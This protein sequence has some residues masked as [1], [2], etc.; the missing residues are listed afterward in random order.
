MNL[1]VVTYIYQENVQTNQF[2]ES[3]NHMGLPLVN[4]CKKKYHSGHGD[5]MQ[6]IYA[7][8]Q[9][10]RGA[11][12]HAM[13]CDGGDSFF[14]RKPHEHELPIGYILY[15]AEKA[16]YPSQEL[17]HKHPFTMSPW[18]YLNG[19]GWIAPIDLYI[20]WMERYGLRSFRGDINGQLEL[21][22]A[23]LKSRDEQFPIYLDS[24]CGLFQTLAFEEHGD[25]AIAHMHQPYMEHGKVCNPIFINLHTKSFPAVLH[26]NGRVNMDW[27][28]NTN[29]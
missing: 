25:F 23:F 17:A 28:Y 27:I 29:W 6:E 11:Y 19:G 9:E 16:C 24:P 20:Q 7:C 21:M 3:V 22:Q 10:L 14:V 4:A 26:G 15:S 12:T 5:T 18:K 13:Y 8:L 1:V 2:V